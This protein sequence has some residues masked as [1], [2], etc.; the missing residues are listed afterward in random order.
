MLNNN[1]MLNNVVEENLELTGDLMNLVDSV[2]LE[3][4]E[5]EVNVDAL[6]KQA[7]KDGAK[8]A[9]MIAGGALVVYGGTLVY[10]KF[11]S[12][13]IKEFKGNGE[14]KNFLS[15]LVKKKNKAEETENDIEENDLI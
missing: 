6:F 2:E 14:N 8:L 13:K 10:K 5:E 4:L 9:L 11:I 12:P 3:N 15:A 1:E 7:E